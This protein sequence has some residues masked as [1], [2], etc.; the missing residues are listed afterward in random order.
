L[1]ISEQ[2]TLHNRKTDLIY[3]MDTAVSY[4]IRFLENVSER[5]DICVDKNGPSIIIKSDIYKSNYVKAK[6]RGAKI[7]FITEI[8]KDNIQYWADGGTT[9]FN[10]YLVF[11]PRH[12]CGIV[13]LTNKSDAK[14]FSSLP[15]IAYEIFKAISKK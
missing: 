6:N 1:N 10:S 8:T 15:G 12:N 14:T 3:D 7:R 2:T 13:I 4:G 11:Y 5:M 9:G